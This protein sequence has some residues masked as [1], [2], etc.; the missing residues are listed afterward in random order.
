LPNPRLKCNTK[1][2]LGIVAFAL[3]PSTKE[4]KKKQNS[5]C[6]DFIHGDMLFIYF[7]YKNSFYNNFKQILY[8]LK[9]IFKNK[10]QLKVFFQIFF[11]KN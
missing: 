5:L 9:P 11:L 7:A 4:K 2:G 1:H 6:F 8:F 3:C 10:T